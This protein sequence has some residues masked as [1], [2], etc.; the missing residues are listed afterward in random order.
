MRNHLARKGFTFL[1]LLSL[2]AC[3]VF[4]ADDPAAADPSAPPPTNPISAGENAKPPVPGAPLDGVFVSSSRGDD[5]AADGSMAKPWKTLAA[6]MAHAEKVGKRVIACAETYP[7]VLRVRSGVSVYG[8]FACDGGAFRQDDARRARVEAP[9]SP[10]LVAEGV[11]LPTRLEGLAVVAPDGTA[12][13]PSSIGAMIRASKELTLGSSEI[14]AGRGADGVDGAPPSLPLAVVAD[15]DDGVNAGNCGPSFACF[16]RGQTPVPGG[17]GAPASACPGG[18]AGGAGGEGGGGVSHLNGTKYA[19]AT[20]GA[21]GTPATAPGGA[22]DPYQ[23]APGQPG[24]AGA[25]GADGALGS[26]EL[27]A[28]GIV[29]RDGAR[30]GDGQPGQGGGGGGGSGSV[31]IDT[32]HFGPSGGGGGAGG[33]PGVA[34]TAGTTGGSSVALY[35]VR[36]RVIV[37]RSTLRSSDAGRAGRGSLGTIST[38]GGRGGRGGSGTVVVS[39]VERTVYSGAGGAGGA[40]GA[41]GVSGHGAAGLSVALIEIGGGVDARGTTLAHGAGGEGAPAESN[42]EAT[43][44]AAPSG[45]ADDR[46]TLD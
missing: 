34:G 26:V 41:A 8:Y 31:N 25:R 3:G 14:T 21:G 16:L 1:G 39:F 10:A 35:V 15:G 29:A 23:S 6:A 18:S 46:V 38:S 9:G 40:G 30:G 12:E 20:S 44:P 36:S 13:R 22:P 11:D 19:G 45:R 33:C 27:G 7:E 5:A 4:G 24:A 2:T 17:A 37:E 42:V 28:D 43:L 32:H